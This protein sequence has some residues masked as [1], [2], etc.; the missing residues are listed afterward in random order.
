ML[1]QEAAKRRPAGLRHKP[2]MRMVKE[3][4]EGQRWVDID[5]GSYCT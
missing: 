4:R 2:L 3:R 5:V 1:V